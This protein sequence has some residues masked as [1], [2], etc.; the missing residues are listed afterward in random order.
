VKVPNAAI[1][2]TIAIGMVGLFMAC[3]TW[4]GD[5][6]TIAAVMENKAVT[7]VSGWTEPNED[8]RCN[9]Q[10]YQKRAISNIEKLNATMKEAVLFEKIS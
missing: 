6:H 5:R 8:S 1:L 4:R 2:L 7:K 3:L 10:E 9:E